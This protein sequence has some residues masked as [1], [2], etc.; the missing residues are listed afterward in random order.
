[1]PIII[2]VTKF[3]VRR[4]HCVLAQ[5]LVYLQESCISKNLY[6]LHAAEFETLASDAGSAGLFRHLNVKDVYEL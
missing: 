2:P 5:N 3:E 4:A 6:Q 1:M